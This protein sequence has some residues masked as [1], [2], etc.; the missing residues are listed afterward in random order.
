[1]PLI[2]GAL[3][4]VGQFLTTW[5]VFFFGKK[6]LTFT[7]SVAAFIMLTVAF[8]VCIKKIFVAILALA[9]IPP[10][11]LVALGMFIPANFAAILAS[12]ASAESCKWAYRQAKH[13]ISLMNNAA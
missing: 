11:V 4:W 2:L 9:I 7:T 10:W 13:K 3:T 8:V 6:A 5:A 12:I 1:M